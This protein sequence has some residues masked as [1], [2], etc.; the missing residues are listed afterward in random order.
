MAAQPSKKYEHTTRTVRTVKS[1][2]R[3]G[4]TCR[5]IRFEKNMNEQRE[6]TAGGYQNMG[7][8]ATTMKVDSE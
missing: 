4:A 7:A 5:T 8:T 1:G 6:T 3:A 2:W